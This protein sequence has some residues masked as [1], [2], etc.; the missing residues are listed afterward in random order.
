MDGESDG[1]SAFQSGSARK[2]AASVSDTS[3]PSKGRLPVNNS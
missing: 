2:T 1:G 3:S